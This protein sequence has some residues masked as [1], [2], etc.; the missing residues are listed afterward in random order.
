MYLCVYILQIKQLPSRCCEWPMIS[1]H[2]YLELLVWPGRG[3][4]A[5]WTI[6]S[7]LFQACD[8]KNGNLLRCAELWSDFIGVI[9]RSSGLGQIKRCPINNSR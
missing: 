8:E 9:M 3:R 4:V 6:L 1:L 2:S 7:P 5:T